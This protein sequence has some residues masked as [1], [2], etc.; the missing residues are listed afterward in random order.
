MRLGAIYIVSLSRPLAARE[1]PVGE[2][3]RNSFFFGGVRETVVGTC[4]KRRRPLAG[5][6]LCDRRHGGEQKEGGRRGKER[7]GEQT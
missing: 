1:S 4:T 2:R 5:Y 3:R 6:N 7:D